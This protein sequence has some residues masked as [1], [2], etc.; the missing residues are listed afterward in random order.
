MEIKLELAPNSTYIHHRLRSLEGPPRGRG[1]VDMGR[2][3]LVFACLL[4]IA[5]MVASSVPVGAAK[6]GNPGKSGGDDD[7]ALGTGALASRLP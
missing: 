5:L 4:M 1:V 6:G 3:T 2:R 7:S